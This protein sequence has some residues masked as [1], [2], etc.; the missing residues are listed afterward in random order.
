M[1]LNEWKNVRKVHWT[2]NDA[3][4]PPSPT[5]TPNEAFNTIRSPTMTAIMRINWMY[6]LFNTL[7]P[8]VV[9][10]LYPCVFPTSLQL[11][12][13]QRRE[14]PKATLSV[15]RSTPRRSFGGHLIVQRRLRSFKK[16]QFYNSEKYPN[17]CTINT[18]KSVPVNVLMFFQFF[19]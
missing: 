17:H 1:I 11:G 19:F 2:P 3:V 8:L 12:N 18:Y 15:S 14:A 6:L 5:C 7:S 10:K 13:I 16:Y 4:F 9:L